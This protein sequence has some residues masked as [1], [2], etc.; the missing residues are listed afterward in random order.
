VSSTPPTTEA[1]PATGELERSVDDLEEEYGEELGDV[2]L[3]P[4]PDP[5][6]PPPEIVVFDIGEVLVDETRVW[7]CWAE[8][9]GVSALEFAAVL[10]AAIAQGQDHQAVFEH[11]AP[12][13]E[14][15]SFVEEHER[16][17]GGIRAEDL[18][19][20][21]RLCLEELR[22]LGVRVLLAGNQP[23]R[24][25]AQLEALDLGVDGMAM[26]EDLGVDK[27]DPAFFEAVL[28]LADTTDPTEVLYVG[29]RVDNDVL[30][31]MEFGLSACWI[32]R[33]PWG[34]LQELP[35]GAQPELILDGLGELPL[36]LAQWRSG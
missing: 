6:G 19:P 16:R 2:E 25:H 18:Y 17:Y 20:D 30:P 13:V 34:V 10:G 8:L 15:E 22:E 33:G 32:R 31:A 3:E 14:W 7:A 26:S 28:R 11:V 27:P 9:L 24:R 36:L 29:D 12:N 4:V 1:P 5:D 35:D 23:S 21:V